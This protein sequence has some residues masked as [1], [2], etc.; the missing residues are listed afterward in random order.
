MSNYKGKLEK[1]ISKY[2]E[3][4]VFRAVRDGKTTQRKGVSTT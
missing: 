4:Q 1:L 3:Q 2:Y